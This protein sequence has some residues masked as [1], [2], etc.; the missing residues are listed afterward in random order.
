M[1]NSSAKVADA[2]LVNGQFYTVDEEKSWAEAVAIEDGI[3]VYV[4]SMEG[5]DPY[6]GKKTDVVDLKGK[7]AL[8]AFV[9]SHLHPLA[10]AYAYN[11]QA[12]L[13]DL[14]THEEY[15]AAI[16]EYAQNHPE[17][18]GIMGA[19]FDF[20][21]YDEIKPKKEWLDAIDSE[22][23][24]GI[25]D[26]DIHVMW[27]N[28]KVF[29]M[30]GWD[31][32]TPDPPGGIIDRD[33]STGEPSG[34]LLEMP[35]MGPAWGLFQKGTKEEY[36]ESLLWISDWM[37][38]E[39]ITTA[40]DAWLESDPNYY[41]AYDELAKAGQL[42]VRYRGSWYIDDAGD[43]LNEIDQGLRTIQGF[44]HPHFQVN[45]F[46]FMADGAGETALQLEGNPC[47]IK[48]WKDEY[49]VNA[50]NK[51]EKEGQQIHIHTIGD[52]AVKY[53]L[54][55]LEK[56]QEGNGERDSRHSL[57]HVERAR[58]EDVKRM[59]GLGLAAHITPLF[60][61]EN[62]QGNESPYQSLF[63][64]GVNVTSAS[65]WTTSRFDPI[66]IISQGLSKSSVSLEQMIRAGT[67]NG[68]YANFL[69]DEIGSIEVGKKADIVVLTKNLFSIDTEEIP[70]VKVAMT[71]FEGKRVY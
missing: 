13:F 40:H 23:P 39:G 46:K 9:D 6:I 16:G 59:G 21:L 54:D 19:G 35:A 31:A 24:M 57:V 42:T 22:R 65:D 20:Y 67:I 56:V 63:D 3:I 18:D 34:L 48:V 66:L 5:I 43:Y 64:A 45:S 15:I 4:G 32:N 50:F 25:I 58:S 47:G 10:N 1:S 11:F 27:V 36:K 53:A 37:N 44:T 28:S 38:R 62:P 7:F 33:P 17:M 51:V 69:E 26:K 49:M 8:P 12:A 41:K 71:F 61:S 2:A 52:G 55:A 14:N 70:N 29:E 30:L 68:A 60:L